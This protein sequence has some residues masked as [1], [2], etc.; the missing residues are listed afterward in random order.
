MSHGLYVL[1]EDGKT[2]KPVANV[3]EWGN[4]REKENR[5]VRFDEID[6]VKISTVFLGIDHAFGFAVPLLFETM[7]FGGKHDDYQDRCSTWEQAQEMHETALR[8]VRGEP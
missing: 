8:L 2:P 3:I 1:G 5:Q 4:A 6:G 7:I